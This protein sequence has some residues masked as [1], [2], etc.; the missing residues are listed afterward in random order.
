[1]MIIDAHAHLSESDFGNVE[2]YH[3]QLKSAGIDMGVVVPGGMVDVRKMTEYITGRLQPENVIPNNAYVKTAFDNPKNTLK[4]FACIDPHNDRALEILEESSD[5]G[6]S[7]LKFSP[8]THQF[9]FASKAVMNLVSRCG[10]L[11][12]P[13]YTHVLYNPGASTNRFINLAQQFPKVNFILGHMGFGPADQEGLDAAVSLDNFYLET[14]TGN[15]LHI[16]ESIKKAGSGKIIFGSEFPLSHPKAEIE[17][18]M[19][20]NL[21]D[22]DLDKVLGNNILSLLPHGRGRV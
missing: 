21:S 15:Y 1:M 9:S 5:A 22:H 7:G 6:F 16:K 12:F 8:I 4:G 17:K 3:E 10:E 14:S 13:V 11:G 18:I 20:L 2:I 19:L